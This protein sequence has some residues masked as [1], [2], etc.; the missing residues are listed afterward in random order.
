MLL[1][2]ATPTKCSL[3]LQFRNRSGMLQRRRIESM[4]KSYD[5]ALL[6]PAEMGAADRAAIARG[7]S[8]VQLM[9][10][11]GRAV[12]Q[13]VQARWPRQPIVVLCGPGN[14]GGDGFTAARHLARAGWPVRV[15][16]L[17]SIKQLRGDAAHH[18]GLWQDKVEPFSLEVLDGAGVVIDAIFGAGLARPVEGTAAEM[19]EGVKVQKLPVCAVDV[20]S[21]LD[22]ATGEIRGTAPQAEMTV[23]FF[24]KKPGH[25]LFPGRRLCGS[26]VVAD[27][28]IPSAVL[29]DIA[30]KTFENSPELWLE[31]YPWPQPESHKYQRGHVLVLGGDIMTGASRLTAKGVHAHRSRA[32]HPRSALQGMAS[33]RNFA[34]RDHRAAVRWLGWI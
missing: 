5:N 24:R 7:V 4:H 6:T 19:I 21:G 34:D 2:D 23:T 8:G 15:A 10:A 30:P 11:A 12:A 33:L 1:V 16:L 25:V 14:N 29:E 9:E 18:A 32:N 3:A 13:N 22:G 27:I 20:P 17:C 28:G 31:K 26:T